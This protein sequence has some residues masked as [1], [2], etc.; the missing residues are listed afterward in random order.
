M[1][2]VRTL[3]EAVGA[4][5]PKDV[6]DPAIQESIVLRGDLSGLNEQQK[7]NY[8]LFRCRQVGLDAAAKPFD[9]LKLNGKEILYANAGATQQLCAI[10]KLSTQITHRERIDDIYVVSVRVTGADGRVS[11]NQGAVSVGAARGDAL[12]NAILKSTTKAIR[13]AVLAHC[14]LGM[15]DETE[16]ETIPG[17][18]RAAPAVETQEVQ[19]IETPTSGIVFMVPG[20]KEP[21]AYYPNDEDWVDGFLSM[22]DK[23]GDSKKFEIPEKLSKLD[24]LYECNEFIADTIR[25]AKPGLWQVMSTG[26][27]KVKQELALALRDGYK[28]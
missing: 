26:I 8:Y 2:N 4:V 12:A 25:T 19:A 28:A 5:V 20:A 9:L 6:L 1:S 16:V 22:V 7:K 11:E 23:I 13:R 21:Y 3:N 15:M 10:H 17:A 24:A 27:G 14:G 18:V